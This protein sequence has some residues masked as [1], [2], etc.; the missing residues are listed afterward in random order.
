M[1]HQT[2]MQTP[3]GEMHPALQLLLLPLVSIAVQRARN[4]TQGEGLEY[5]DLL[6]GLL[7]QTGAEGWDEVLDVANR[8]ATQLLAKMDQV[9]AKLGEQDEELRT[10][11]AT[12]KSPKNNSEDIEKLKEDYAPLAVSD[13]R[14]HLRR[15]A[16]AGN[17][18]LISALLAV[19]TPVSIGYT[20][21][22]TP[23]HAAADTMQYSAAV[24]L[25]DAGAD[26]NATDSNRQTP[27]H[28]A[29]YV[30]DTAVVELLLDRN[31][32]LH[33]LDQDNDTPLHIAAKYGCLEVVRA[34]VER[35]GD[36]KRRNK[37]GQTPLDL[38]RNDNA[39]DVV[40]WL[41]KLNS[42]R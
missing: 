12:L 26:V 39:K 38:A 5:Q 40:N 14:H 32:H 22:K 20:R 1:L 37:K 17:L 9:L 42:M 7:N 24:L 3:L 2:E 31:A 36:P 34:L 41:A 27:L 33:A 35:G 25:L 18:S 16:L 8:S 10:G 11:F 15:A 4:G 23:L 29:A 13:R 30:T 19:G 6:R 21:G 28:H